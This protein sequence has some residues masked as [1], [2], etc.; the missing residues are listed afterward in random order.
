[1]ARPKR[2][3]VIREG[4]VCRVLVDGVKLPFTLPRETVRVPVHPDDV[5]TVH[6]TL[7][8]DQVDVIN[9]LHP[10]ESETD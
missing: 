2:I 3:Q 10:H 4:H 1:M 7:L 5:P 8:A 9:K 6:L